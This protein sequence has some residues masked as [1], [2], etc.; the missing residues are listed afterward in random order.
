M[1]KRRYS[2]AEIRLFKFLE[3]LDRAIELEND[4][5]ARIAELERKAAE[6]ATKGQLF[7]IRDKRMHEYCGHD[8][9][10]LKTLTRR[11]AKGI[12]DR[13]ERE[14]LGRTK[15]KPKKKRRK[16]NK[17]KKYV[18]LKTAFETQGKPNMSGPGIIRSKG[19]VT[20]S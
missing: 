14:V 2:K 7:Y 12:I 16:R 9:E 18:P 11:G 13:W 4:Q 3:R 19:P 17:R 5:W 15:P 1:T 10:Y 8:D 20:R 6:P